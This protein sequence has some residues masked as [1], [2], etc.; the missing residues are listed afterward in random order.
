MDTA[1]FMFAVEIT[2]PYLTSKKH[3]HANWELALY[4]A[5]VGVATVG[6][7][8]IEIRPGTIVCYPPDR[9]HDE[10]ATVGCTGYF[11]HATGL[12]L[13]VSP[14][15]VGDDSA[16]HAVGRLSAM[17]LDESRRRGADHGRIVDALFGVLLLHVDRQLHRAAAHPCVEA[18]KRTIHERFREP[19]FGVG[20]AMRAQPMS[21]D[22][23]RRLFERDTG[24]TP[25]TFLA[26]LRVNEA[27]NLLAFGYSVKEAAARVGFP[28]Q[29]YFSRAFHKIAGVRPSTFVP[30][31]PT[32]P[33]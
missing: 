26:D 21:K 3:Q 7:E 23:L 33:P 16:D 13:P 1:R 30:A 4:T 27:K 8:R 10:C 28:D 9:P 5:G 12:R 11:L 24:I 29:H 20:E 25:Q 2:S 32:S 14:V 22:H 6:S 15:A 18:L 31:A 17:L 19:D